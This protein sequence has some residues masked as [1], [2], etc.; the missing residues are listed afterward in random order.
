MKKNRLYFCSLCFN[1]YWR[2]DE[3]FSKRVKED[4]KSMNAIYKNHAKCRGKKR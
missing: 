2:G 1:Y 3:E 4:P